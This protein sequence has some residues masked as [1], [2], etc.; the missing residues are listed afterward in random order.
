LEKNMSGN[1]RRNAPDGLRM[2]LR[3]VRAGVCGLLGITALALM[4]L[5]ARAQTV[6]EV[7]TKNIQAHGGLEKI[8]AMNTLRNSGKINFGSIRATLLQENKRS[9]DAKIRSS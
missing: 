1:N 3:T 8:R 7:I 4:P 9:R 6:D 2:A 5:V